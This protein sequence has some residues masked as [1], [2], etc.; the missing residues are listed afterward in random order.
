MSAWAERSLSVMNH[1]LIIESIHMFPTHFYSTDSAHRNVFVSRLTSPLWVDTL[2]Q[3][4]AVEQI[5][6]CFTRNGFAFF[7]EIAGAVTRVSN[8]FRA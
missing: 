4:M 2:A 5:G 3:L 1:E 8:L 6:N 7:I